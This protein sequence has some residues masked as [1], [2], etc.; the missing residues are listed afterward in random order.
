MLIVPKDGPSSPEDH[1]ALAYANSM[2]A[3]TTATRAP[4]NTDRAMVMLKL[5]LCR[6]VLGPA[7]ASG[8]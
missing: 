8:P 4:T 2:T 6:E 5:L 7:D 1:L 3:I